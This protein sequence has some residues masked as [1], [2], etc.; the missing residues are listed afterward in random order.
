[1]GR[2]GGGGGRGPTAS[3]SYKNKSEAHRNR[4]EN[5]T[6]ITD[7]IP[8]ASSTRLV[9]AVCDAPASSHTLLRALSSHSVRGVGICLS[10]LDT[11]LRV[12]RALGGGGSG[13]SNMPGCP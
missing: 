12:S 2:G 5:C 7:S 13:S 1:M 11:P 9:V 6:H 10:L 8:V 4:E 3:V